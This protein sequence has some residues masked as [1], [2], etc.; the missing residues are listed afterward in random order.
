MKSS[1]ILI[2]ICL[3]TIGLISDATGQNKGVPPTKTPEFKVGQI[4]SYKTRTTEAKSTFIIVKI[5]KA[6]KYGK[7]IHIALRDLKMKN[8]RSRD[9]FSDKINH[10]PFAEK[11]VG[12]S[13]IK[14]LE[15]NAELPDFQEGYALWKEAFDQERAGYYE[16]SIAEAVAV[17]EQT[18]NQ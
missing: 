2:C 18:L 17:A 7:I 9:G 15:E 14:I 16:I 13:A 6:T 3:I 1:S 12:L 8:P 5:D 4:W 11:A 10:M